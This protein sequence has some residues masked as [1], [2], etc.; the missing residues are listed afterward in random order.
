MK[1]GEVYWADLPPLSDL[2]NLGFRVVCQP[3]L[4][5]AKRDETSVVE[6]FHHGARPV[7]TEYRGPGIPAR[8]RPRV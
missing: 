1:R 2:S 5:T 3:E 8:Q 6:A 7:F 4:P